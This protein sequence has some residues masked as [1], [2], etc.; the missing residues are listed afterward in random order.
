MAEATD[1][2]HQAVSPQQEATFRTD[3]ELNRQL[4]E[5]LRPLEAISKNY[6]WSWK[7]PG[8]ALFRDLDPALWEKCEQNPRALLKRVSDL[9]LW[10]RA[11]DADYVQRVQAFWSD[12]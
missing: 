11:A 6:Y 5:A 9:R 2:A 3:F 4:P 7:R 8:V 12:H 1:I 10:Q